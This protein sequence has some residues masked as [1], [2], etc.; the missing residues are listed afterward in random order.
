[1]ILGLHDVSLA[2]VAVTLGILV[3]MTV[4][5]FTALRQSPK[6]ASIL[7]WPMAVMALIV[8]L[9]GG[10]VVGGQE[11]SLDTRDTTIHERLE[12]RH[13]NVVGWR[14][15]DREVVVRIKSGCTAAYVIQSGDLANNSRLWPLVGGTAQ[16]VSGCKG[17][18]VERTFGPR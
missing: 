7:T 12:T 10:G 6:F 3:L 9:V 8:A 2:V 11:S 15:W 16:V 1:M 5:F 4:G 13:I 18:N 14:N 17:I